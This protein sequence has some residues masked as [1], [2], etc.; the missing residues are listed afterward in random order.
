MKFKLPKPSGPVIHRTDLKNSYGKMSC[1]YVGETEIEDPAEDI[2]FY[3]QILADAIAAREWENTNRID[4]LAAH[5]RATYYDLAEDGGDVFVG[6][7]KMSDDYK[8]RWRA[9]VRLIL[10][11]A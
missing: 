2:N 4:G 3:A 6:W 5:A 8:D 10:A 9:V 1:Y 7:E 11:H